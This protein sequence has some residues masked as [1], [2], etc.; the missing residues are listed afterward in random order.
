MSRTGGHLFRIAATSFN[1]SIEPGIWISVNTKLISG[2]ASE[3][4]LLRQ[5]LRPQRYQT[6]PLPTYPP[7]SF[8]LIDRRQLT[9]PH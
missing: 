2:R 6:P 4:L 3:S 8:E 1:P 9:G 7:R 5:R